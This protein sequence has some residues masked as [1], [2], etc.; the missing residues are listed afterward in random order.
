MENLQKIHTLQGEHKS[1]QFPWIF[2]WIIIVLISGA[3]LLNLVQF[4][5]IE[6]NNR[7][8]YRALYRYNTSNLFEI[9]ISRDNSARRWVGPFYYFGQIFPDSN[10]IIPRRGGSTW[11]D[12]PLAMITFGRAR[13]I[14]YMDYDPEK[15]AGDLNLTPYEMDISQYVPSRG[16]TRAMLKQRLAIFADETG[17][18]TFVVVTPGGQPGRDGLIMFVESTLLYPDFFGE[19]QDVQ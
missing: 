9:A 6:E 14:I 13:D 5:G 12:L 15:L 2:P 19:P 11:F 16:R 7:H 3:I 8:N 18:R 10:I 1:G 4:Y 17:S